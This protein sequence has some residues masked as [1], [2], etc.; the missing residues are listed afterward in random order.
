MNKMSS[1]L[2]AIL[3]CCS[4]LLTCGQSGPFTI[5]AR[6][7]IRIVDESGNTTPARVWIDVDSQRFFEP[8]TPQTATVYANDQSFSCD[9]VFTM[10]V[11]AGNAVIHVEKGKEYTPVDLAI[12]LK[13]GE[14]IENTIQLKRWIDLPSEG[15]YSADLHVHLGQ[16]NP[17]ILQQLALADD[18]HLMPAFTYWLRGQEESW[19]A[20]WPDE[21]YTTPIVI[22]DRHLITRNN[23]EIERI[24]GNA[25]PGRTIGA[26]FLFNLDHPLTARQFGEHFPTDAALCRIAR[27]QSPGVVFDSDKP[28]WAETVIG[29]ALG[30]LDTIQICHNHYHRWSTLVGGWGMIGP[31]SAGESNAAVGDGLFHRTNNLYYRFLNCGFRLG[32]SGGSAI[33]VMEVPAGYNRVYA[34]IDGP[35]TA[36]KMWASIKAGRSFATSGPMLTLDADDRGPGAMISRTSSDTGPIQLTATLRSIEALESLQLVHNG[37]V[38]ATMSLLDQNPAPILRQTLTY[39]LYP[40]R[41]G[42]IAARALYRAPDGLLRQA[43]TSPVYVSVDEK[44]TAFAEDATYMLRWI[45]ILDDIARSQPDRFPSATARQEVLANYEEARTRYE[46]IIQDAQHHWGDQPIHSGN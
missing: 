29:A 5:Q 41:S 32:V 36:D 6:I 20:T 8:I 40:K 37:R 2:F 12:T 44:P 25:E 27:A 4:I 15:W 30:V 14:T 22:D 10:E 21:T 43:H 18:V 19:H 33:G 46:Q 38:V 3:F 26:T 28:S 17:R 13:A 31:L 45:Q 1:L 7:S 39:E 42:W 11:P 9:G 34:R 24:D 35:L 23:I 16:D